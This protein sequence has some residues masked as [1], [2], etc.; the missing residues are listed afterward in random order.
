MGKRIVTYGK[1]DGDR[2]IPLTVRI[3]WFPDGHIT[4]K[5]YWTPDGSCYTIVSHAECV[6]L[7]FLKE[8]G[9][10]LR[11]KARAQITDAPE[12]Y[13]DTPEQ[14]DVYIY[15]ADNRFYQR[16]IIDERYKHPHKEY[17]T[18]TL[19]VFPDGSYE[20]I[21]FL[22]REQRYLV[23]RTLVVEP[24]GSFLAGGAGIWHKVKARAVNLHDDNDPN[25]KQSI[26]RLAVLYLEFNKWFVSVERTA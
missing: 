7:A 10:G 4:P 5:M 18:V 8:Q 24:R 22:F 6:P 25:P 15:L 20:L 21:C 11:V 23:E 26:C 19:D 14:Q 17:I 13:P 9:E 16:N 2:R 12:P 1:L 3:D